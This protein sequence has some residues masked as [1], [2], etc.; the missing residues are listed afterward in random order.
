MNLPEDSLS[1]LKIGTAPP[2]P[3]ADRSFDVVITNSVLEFIRSS[4]EQYVRDWYRVLKIGGFLVISTENCWFPRD[5]YT[6]MWLPRLRRK[7]AKKKNMPYGAS[8]LEIRKWIKSNGGYFK[9]IS[10]RLL[11]NSSSPRRM[12]G[13]R[14]LY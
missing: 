8:Y 2:L 5:Y 11:K 9:D 6:D 4:R 14:I 13:S 10:S 3:F 12:P 1:V 7:Q